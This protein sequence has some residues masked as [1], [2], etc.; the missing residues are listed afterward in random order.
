[1]TDRSTLAVSESRSGDGELAKKRSAKETI[2]LL[3]HDLTELRREL[4]QERARK[5]LRLE[6]RGEVS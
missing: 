2:Q 6:L 5:P 1:M 3:V 4:A